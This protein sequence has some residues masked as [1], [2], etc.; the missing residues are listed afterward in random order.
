MEAVGQYLERLALQGTGAWSVLS[1]FD[2]LLVFTC[3]LCAY[4]TVSR[5]LWVRRSARP[6][7]VRHCM[8]NSWPGYCE[9]THLCWLIGRC[10]TWMKRLIDV[11]V[12]SSRTRGTKKPLRLHTYLAR[13][14]D[15]DLVW[16]KIVFVLWCCHA[17]IRHDLGLVWNGLVFVTVCTCLQVSTEELYR[18]VVK[19][20]TAP[21]LD[22]ETMW[23]R[24]IVTSVYYSYTLGCCAQPLLVFLQLREKYDWIRINLHACM[25]HEVHA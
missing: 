4:V 20:I 2:Q 16:L 21:S 13:T 7:P 12:F 5:A 22:N 17:Y 3:I 9:C 8:L 11:F 24:V 6:Y 23:V 19:F 10:M 18:F 25:H 15:L 1:L 14:T